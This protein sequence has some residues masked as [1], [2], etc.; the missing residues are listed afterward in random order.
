MTRV[1][2]LCV[3][4]KMAAVVGCI[5][6][7]VAQAQAVDTLA[8]NG[9]RWREVGPFRGGRSVAVAGSAA[10]QNEYWMGTTG[11]GVFKTVDGGLS[12]APVTDRYF[13]EQ[14]APCR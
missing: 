1:D 7:A 12:W 9:I 4:A 10:R 5:T 14:S 13:G 2:R 6:S 11:G 8:L 3:W